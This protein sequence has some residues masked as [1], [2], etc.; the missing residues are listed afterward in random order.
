MTIN[1]NQEANPFQ[2]KDEFYFRPKYEDYSV[3]STYIPMRDGIK[4]AATIC[5]PKGVSPDTKLPTLLYQ[6]RYQRTHHLRLPFRWVWKETVD[7]YPN[8]ELF[9]AAEYVFVYVDV[10]GCGA[11]YGFRYTPFSKEEVLDG[12]DVVDWIISQPWSEGNVVSNGISYTGF[13]AE[14]L[15]TNNHPAVKSIMTGHS[16][17]DPFGD[18][19]FPG[20][21]FNTAFIQVWS[22]VGKQYDKNVTKELKILLPSRWLLTK[23]V[24]HVHSDSDYYQLKEAIKDHQKNLFVFDNIRDVSYR[25]D[26]INLKEIKYEN[27]F[28]SHSIYTK[29]QELQQ[30]NIPIYSWASWLDANFADIVIARFLSLKNPQMAIIGDWNHG[31]HLPANPFYPLRPEVVPSPSERI[32]TEISF[33]N[34]ILQG[35]LTSKTL[36]YYTMGEER[37]KAVQSWPLSGQSFQRWYLE[38]D[39]YLTTEKPG[40]KDGADDYKINY[41]TST[42]L[43]NRWMAPA[44]LPI[45]YTHRTNADKKLLTYTSSSLEQDVEITG[46]PVITLYLSS[47]HEDG[48]IYVYLEAVDEEENVIYLTD[49]N[50][51]FIHRKISNEEPPFKINSPYHTFM[52]KDALPFPPNQITEI[53]FG[54]HVTSVLIKKGYKLRLAIAGADKDT[55]MRYPAEGKPVVTFERNANH[56]SF[57]DIPVIKRE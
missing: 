29:Q 41:R 12:S 34:R 8:T 25:D 45:D 13:T 21:C 11:S 38:K 35:K 52:K 54:L 7:H 49:G 43:F 32:K 19:I 23:G 6:T 24:K 5:I 15:A 53:K 28:A 14:W 47:T 39:H 37:W 2:Q 18:M 42:G 50:L 56:P 17:W 20:G 46:N 48:A 51:R 1:Q 44:G 31:A 4:L 16:G 36:Y 3:S 10:R 55:F 22:F 30:L 33:F 9:T 27:L 26:I 40:E 57:I